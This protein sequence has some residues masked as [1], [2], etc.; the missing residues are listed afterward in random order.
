MRLLLNNQVA[1]IESRASHRPFRRTGTD[2]YGV[3]C[4][5]LD[6]I[7]LI[8]DGI[9]HRLEA[10]SANST[11]SAL[12]PAG[13]NGGD[14]PSPVPHLCVP[15][16]QSLGLLNRFQVVFADKDL[17]GPCKAACIQWVKA[18]FGHHSSDAAVAASTTAGSV[19]SGTMNHFGSFYTT[20][21]GLAIRA[22]NTRLTFTGATRLAPA[23]QPRRLQQS[24]TIRSNAET[25]KK[26]SR[27]HV[28][29]DTLTGDGRQKWTRHI[30]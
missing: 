16:H 7:A 10:G 22:K 13:A 21:E 24:Q 9:G 14:K 23:G 17:S 12:W 3:F 1:A 19:L 4:R 5:G 11:A 28:S 15:V 8:A 2:W 30:C 20:A 26:C 29:I 27:A 25:A 18:I 6:E